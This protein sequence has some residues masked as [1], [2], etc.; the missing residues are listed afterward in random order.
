MAA[1]PL[2]APVATFLRL[3]L[4]LRWNTLDSGSRK[5]SVSGTAAS[6][7]AATAALRADNDNSH[8]SQ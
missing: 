8:K 2:N 3:R 4:I 7:S 6:N 1:L 5:G